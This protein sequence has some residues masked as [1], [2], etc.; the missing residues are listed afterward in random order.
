MNETS[1]NNLYLL[2]NFIVQG[3]VAIVWLNE[4]PKIYYVGST[5]YKE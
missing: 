1:L 3:Y 5:K 4:W 2:V